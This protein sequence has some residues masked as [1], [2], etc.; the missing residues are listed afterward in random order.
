MQ[1]GE[2]LEF[3]CQYIEDFPM[4]V[5]KK[6]ILRA[7]PYGRE[8]GTDKRIQDEE[9]RPHLFFPEGENRMIC[10]RMDNFYRRSLSAVFRCK[11]QQGLS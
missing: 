9:A 4:T 3:P 5:G 10:K 2:I 7:I 11:F 1:L 6:V 8:V